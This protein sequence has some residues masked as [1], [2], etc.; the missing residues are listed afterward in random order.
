MGDPLFAGMLRE[1]FDDGGQLAAVMAEVDCICNEIEDMYKTTP[2]TASECFD[3]LNDRLPGNVEPDCVNLW[4]VFCDLKEK[5]EE[6]DSLSP[7]EQ[8]GKDVPKGKEQKPI[9]A[10]TA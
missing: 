4:Q 5:E 9:S 8:A 6:W 7:E 1:V 10:L 2:A 3:A